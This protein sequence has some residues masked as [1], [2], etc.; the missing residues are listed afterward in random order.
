MRVK[1]NDVKKLIRESLEKKY[2][3]LNEAEPAKPKKVPAGKKGTAKEKTNVGA[4]SKKVVATAGKPKAQTTQAQQL[5]SALQAAVTGAATGAGKAAQG[6]AQASTLPQVPADMPFGRR[7]L[8]KISQGGLQQGSGNMI[9]L[10]KSG[11]NKL[12]LGQYLPEDKKKEVVREIQKLVGLPAGSQ[13]GIFGKETAGA[14]AAFQRKN[15]L[16][17]DGVVGPKTA[18]SLL[19][20]TGASTGTVAGRQSAPKSDD[21]NYTPAPQTSSNAESDDVASVDTS[22][23]YMSPEYDQSTKSSST[24]QTSVASKGPGFVNTV[25]NMSTASASTFANSQKI[26]DLLQSYSG[27]RLEKLKQGYAKFWARENGRN[28]EQAVKNADQLFSDFIGKKMGSYA[29]DIILSNSGVRVA[30]NL[31][32]GIDRQQGQIAVASKSE[33]KLRIKVN[34][35]KRIISE[36]IKKRSFLLKEGAVTPAQLVEKYP[37]FKEFSEWGQMVK[38]F[39]GD[40]KLFDDVGGWVYASKGEDIW[41][42]RSPKSPKMFN[43]LKDGGEQAKPWMK[44]DKTKNPDSYAAISARLKGEKA[45]QTTAGERY[46][47]KTP[48]PGYGKT[49]TD[50]SGQGSGA[51]IGSTPTQSERKPLTMAQKA[52]R[53]AA[54]Q[55][56]RESEHAKSLGLPG[57]GPVADAFLIQTGTTKEEAQ[58]ALKNLKNRT[59]QG[60]GVKMDSWI[61]RLLGQNS[62]VDAMAGILYRTSRDLPALKGKSVEEIKGELLRIQGEQTKQAGK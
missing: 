23:P 17:A 61:S 47:E 27:D 54:D 10:V 8:T 33:G 25:R 9:R 5:P 62:P 29:G 50:V 2:E 18:G 57:L 1:L 45:P 52:E 6:T 19:G 51:V 14:V 53:E 43:L 3:R 55:K 28:E 44:V 30:G 34:D 11:F 13:D 31:K 42:I 16:D 15:G 7:F 41:I 4:A 58:A 59:G 22:P 46:A 20:S 48:A 56:R 39:P 38:Q 35:L 60:D 24:S 49:T 26:A 37:E 32:N 40:V 21:K 12:D 36:E